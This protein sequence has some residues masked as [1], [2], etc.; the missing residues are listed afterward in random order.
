MLKGR[1]SFLLDLLV[2]LRF[3]PELLP[4]VKGAHE[5][6]K[7]RFHNILVEATAHDTGGSCLV[8]VAVD[9]L[10]HSSK[11]Q[12]FAALCR[13][14]Y[15]RTENAFCWLRQEFVE[16]L[17]FRLCNG[18]NGHLLRHLEEPDTSA[19]LARIL[20]R[21][22]FLLSRQFSSELRSCVSAARDDDEGDAWT[23]EGD[24]WTSETFLPALLSIQSIQCSLEEEEGGGGGGGGRG[25]GRSEKHSY[26]SR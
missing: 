25:V 17:L 5:P 3:F 23:S 22:F 21:H 16:S 9:L 14:R 2:A 19:R 1:K 26:F 20:S 6:E 11:C 12:R 10:Q 7:T 8:K 15:S 18:R 24:A 13:E 4:L